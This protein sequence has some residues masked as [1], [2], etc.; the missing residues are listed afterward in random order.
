M[1]REEVIGLLEPTVNALGFELIDVDLSLGGAN[2]LLRLYINSDQGI[3]LDD[4]S[5]VSEQVSALLDV[6]S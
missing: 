1:T 2:G 3:T 5:A 6:S 4:C